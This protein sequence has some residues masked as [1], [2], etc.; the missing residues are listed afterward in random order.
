M[1]TEGTV[2]PTLYPEL[3]AVLR[4][5]VVSARAALGSNFVAACL[6]GSFA[7][8]DFDRHSDVDFIV[9]LNEEASHKQVQALQTM[10]ERLY[11]LD[12]GWAQHLEGSYF[13]KDILRDYSQCGKSLW[14]LD[15]GSKHTME[16]SIGGD[17]RC[18]ECDRVPIV[19]F[20]SHFGIEDRY[21]I[22]L[23]GLP[24]PWTR[25]PVLGQSRRVRARDQPAM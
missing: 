6:Q 16:I 5:L 18:R 8:G 12:S 24:E 20:F 19:H 14:Y 22:T 21:S 3:N 10:H 17:D 2:D 25:T 13:P 7:V 1:K 9:A 4:E 11:R 15:H 23:D